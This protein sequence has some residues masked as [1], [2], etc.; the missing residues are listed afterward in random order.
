MMTGDVDD[1]CSPWR[2]PEEI[3]AYFRVSRSTVATWVR[4]G[5]VPH[6]RIRTIVRI[7]IHEMLAALRAKSHSSVT[8]ASEQA[9]Q[10]P[11]P[12]KPAS[13]RGSLPA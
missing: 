1:G 7:N 12:R 2:T 9:A 13:R 10:T 8:M 6:F 3:A 11:L 4:N 5:Q